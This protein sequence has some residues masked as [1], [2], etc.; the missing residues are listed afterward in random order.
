[1]CGVCEILQHWVQRT[2][3]GI[4]FRSLLK[5]AT[6]YIFVHLSIIYSSTIHIFFIFVTF[7]FLLFYSSNLAILAISTVFLQILY[8][9]FI[10]AMYF[11]V[12]FCSFLAPTVWLLISSKVLMCQ[13]SYLCFWHHTCSL[14]G[15]VSGNIRACFRAIFSLCLAPERDTIF[16]TLVSQG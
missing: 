5:C 13:C 12:Y 8:F 10:L 16:W 7:N 2:P 3:M 9:G 4:N 6:F 14:R 15:W 1:M 11:A